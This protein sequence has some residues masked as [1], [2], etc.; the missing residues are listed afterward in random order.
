MNMGRTVV[1]TIWFFLTLILAA[2]A[3][4][5]D[6]SLLT[7]NTDLSWARGMIWYQIFPERFHNGDPLNDP[8]A[9][10]VPNA[11]LQPGWQP[12]P[13]TSDWYEFQTWEANKSSD[14][15]EVVFE[16]RYGGDL[17]GVIQKLDYLQELGIEGIYFNPVFEAPSLHK[18]DGSSF[19][20]I[21]DNFG[22][23]PSGDKARIAAA[24]E[25][26]DPTTWIWSSAD[27][28]FLQLINEVHQRGMKIVIDGVFNHTGTEFFA[29]QD[30]IKNQQDSRYA[31]WYDI[32]A[33]D[34]PATPQNEFDYKGWWGYKGLPELA[35][36]EMGFVPEARQYIMH[37]TRRWMDPNGDGDPS[38]GIDGWRLD[39][40][41]EVAIPFWQEWNALVKSINPAAITVAEI[42]SDASPWIE[43]G[44]FDGTM[45]Y[46]FAYPTINFFVDQKRVISGREFA[47]RLKK[48]AQT[49]GQ[50]TSH[51][52]W[53]ML[54]SHDTDRL[55]SM[56]IN[57]DRNYD[58]NARP[59]ANNDYDVR[60]PQE[61]EIHIQK[62]IAVFQMSYLG[63]PIIYYGTEAGMWGADDPD[64]RKPMLWPELTYDE[65]ISHPVPGRSRPADVN[66]FNRDLFN[67]YRDLIQMR[68]TYPVLRHGDLQFIDAVLTKHTIGFR[69][70]HEGQNMI[71]FFNNHDQSQAIKLPAK[72]AE[73]GNYREIFSNQTRSFSGEPVELT[74]PPRGYLIF[75]SE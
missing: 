71:A 43:A 50:Q 70:T 8:Q 63:A 42:W 37:I 54:D 40:A 7:Q 23:D 30:V 3:A 73:P 19:H 69:R 36:D 29:F 61:R 10:E 21:D 1:F 17:I 59:S 9:S 48:V 55:A 33:W 66:V 13:W 62:Q 68:K 44:C 49:Y 16:R 38:D 2:C 20:H 52:L 31:H 18:Y 39:V 51:L 46:Q 65:E 22:P 56:I 6:E 64:D 24:N 26:D 47:K 67:F 35:E 4:Q 72:V 15:Y 34:D 28:T 53:N 45:N 25:S 58:R 57:P 32:V 5:K 12:H 60:K 11:H 27:S 74:I 41:N 14:F 75:V